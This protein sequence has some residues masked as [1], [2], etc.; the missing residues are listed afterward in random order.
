MAHSEE[1]SRALSAAAESAVALAKAEV[2]L[3]ASEAKAWFSRIG[4][5]AVFMWVASV[6][7][8]IF[9]LVLVLTPFLLS[10]RPWPIVVGTLGLGLLL[11]A[12]AGLVAMREF[13][14]LRHL[15][16]VGRGAEALTQ[17]QAASVT[18]H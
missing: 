6:L 1:P 11:A 3:A 16:P 13:R 17:A 12:V 9:L 15:P 14:R 8:Q 18:E 4:L 2:K 7:V 10:F 5:G